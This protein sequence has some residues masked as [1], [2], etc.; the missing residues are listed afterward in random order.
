MLPVEPIMVVYAVEEEVEKN[1]RSE[2][3][4]FRDSDDASCDS[5]MSR[6]ANSADLVESAPGCRRYTYLPVCSGEYNTRAGL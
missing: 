5:V 6:E 3:R 4:M 2:E 1:G